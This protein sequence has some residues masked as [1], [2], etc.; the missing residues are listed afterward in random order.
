[1]A[2][3]A[4]LS[5][6]TLGCAT[7]AANDSSLPKPAAAKSPAAPQ[8]AVYRWGAPKGPAQVDAFAAWLGQPGIWGE[9]FQ[10]SQH[11]YG[12]EGGSWQTGPWSEWKKKQAGRKLIL[13]VTLLPG[14]WNRSGPTTGP[15]AGKPVSF[16]A[17]AAG[18]YN[19]HFKALAENLVKAGLGDSILRL[20]WEMN[21][22]W[23]TWRAGNNEKLFA[24]YWRQIVTTMR[25]VP[26][27]QDLKYCFNPAS[28]WL[29]FP[30][31]ACYP[32]D[33]YVDYIGVDLYDQSWAPNTYPLPKDATADDILTRQ[34]LAWKELLWGNHG[35][36]FWSKF[37]ADHK[38]PFTIPEWGVCHRGD[39]HG[40]EDN[41][42]F[43]EQMAKF[44]N[45]PAN[46]VAWHCYF[47]VT[48]GDGDHLLSPGAP[49]E[50]PTVFP[51]SSAK[52]KELFG[53][54]SLSAS[55]K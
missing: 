18:D 16:T 37:A 4:A 50:K 48:A 45:D 23:Y 9:D 6:L 26:G 12:V 54:P 2:A 55:G 14:G 10:P 27:A 52:F 15:D 1:M 7:A 28:G 47:D 40:G 51:Q 34:K 36:M 11:W 17:A 13:S 38:K 41:P 20:G 5:A 25:A 32:G 49:G 24:E 33:D 31:E 30:A 39:G 44:I 8:I 35:L 21:G 42:F 29:Q 43:V 3:A 46:N 19:S 53:G 22:G